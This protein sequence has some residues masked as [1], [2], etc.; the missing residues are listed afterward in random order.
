MNVNQ[1]FTTKSLKVGTKELRLVRQ[2]LLLFLRAYINILA[3]K[4]PRLQES[5]RLN[6]CLGE[7]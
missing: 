6:N 3:T 5:P 1:E 4:A 2:S 7:P